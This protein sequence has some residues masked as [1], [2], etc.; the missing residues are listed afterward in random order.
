MANTFIAPRMLGATGFGIYNFIEDF[1]GRLYGMLNPGVT[2]YFYTRLSQNPEA[3][4]LK[5]FFWKLALVLIGVAAAFTAFG[6]WSGQAERLWPDV[7]AHLVVFGLG[8]VTCLWLQGI[9]V[10]VV[11]AHAFTVSGEWAKLAVKLG[12]AAVLAILYIVG[13]HSLEAFFLYRLL[14]GISMIGALL[15]VMRRRGAVT[16][17]NRAIEANERRKIAGDFWQYS[18]PLVGFAIF[19]GAVSIGDRWLLQR[20]AGSEEQGF[21]SLGLKVATLVFLVVQPVTTLYTRDLSRAHGHKDN[22]EI[23]RLTSTLLPRFFTIA[24]Y[25]SIFTALNAKLVALLAGGAAFEDGVL[26]IGVMSLYPLAQTY[27]QLS[28]AIFFATDQTRMYRNVGIV[29]QLI[30]LPVTWVLLGPEKWGGLQL[31]AVGIA[32]KTVFFSL[33]VSNTFLLV[34]C[35]RM[36]IPYGRFLSQELMCCGAFV[37]CALAAKSLTGILFSLS[38]GLLSF[39]VN[40]IVYTLFVVVTVALIP[41]VAGFPRGEI[42][43]LIRS[44]RSQ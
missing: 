30:G 7:P 4:D 27:G 25:F 23:K 16:F 28:T 43:R 35:R 11:D 20:F 17:P 33:I 1:F 3:R 14:F 12:A 9:L 18:S 26:A 22:E 21:F 40:G 2:T 24:A 6:L 29:F 38:C 5:R 13:A 10:Q 8:V 39:F 36:R 34:C 15:W 37:L 19:S 44:F 32:I 41:S 31:G 42:V